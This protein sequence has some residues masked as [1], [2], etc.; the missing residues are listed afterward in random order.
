MVVKSRHMLLELQQ[1]P[2]LLRQRL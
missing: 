1:Y 2:L